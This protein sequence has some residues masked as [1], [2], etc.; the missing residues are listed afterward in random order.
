[1]TGDYELSPNMEI[2]KMTEDDL[3]QV[4]AIEQQ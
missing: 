2:R 1:M 4:I 3:D